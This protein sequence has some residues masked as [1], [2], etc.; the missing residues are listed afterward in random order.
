[1][2]VHWPLTVAVAGASE[3]DFQRVV[4]LV[5]QVAVVAEHE[6][7]VQEALVVELLEQ[8]SHWVPWEEVVVCSHLEA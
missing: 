5:G 8:L 1:M 7:E 3:E 2:V 6:E 4:A